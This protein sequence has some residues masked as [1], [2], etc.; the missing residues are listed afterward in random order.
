MVGILLVPAL[1]PLY[2][3]VSTFRSMCAVPNMAVFCSSLTSWF[4]GMLLTY[5]LNYLK[6]TQSRLLLLES[7]LFLHSTCVVFLLQGL[8]ILEFSR[9]FFNHVSFPRNSTS[10]IIHVFFSL[11]RIVMSGLLLGIVLSV[12][13]CWFYSMVTLPP[14][15]VSTDFG[16]CSY[17]CFLSNCILAI[18]IIL[19][20]ICLSDW[21]KIKSDDLTR[22][23]V[24]VPSDAQIL[25]RPLLV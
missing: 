16:T 8:Y 14:W 22:Q 4:P 12:W 21:V 5:F 15:P 11:L 9:L 24:R 19:T 7:P 20:W 18:F 10:I 3:Y 13:T 25:T 17:Q 6:W 23:M 1:T 2:L